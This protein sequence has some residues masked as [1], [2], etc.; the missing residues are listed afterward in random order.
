G[1]AGGQTTDRVSR[2]WVSGTVSRPGAAYHRANP[3]GLRLRAHGTLG[4]PVLVLTA[5]A[6]PPGAERL[7]R[8]RQEPVGQ[9]GR[10]AG[11]GDFDRGELSGG[12]AGPLAEISP[13]HRL[14]LPGVF[15]VHV[16]DL[17]CP[18]RSREALV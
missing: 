16:C 9:Q 1:M 2:T 6:E 4:L 10:V 14:S 8:C 5:L 11:R 15:P 17:H 18:P 3:P 13:G 12:V 7:E